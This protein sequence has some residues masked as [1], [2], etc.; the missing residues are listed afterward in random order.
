MQRILVLALCAGVALSACSNAEEAASEAPAAEIAQSSETVSSASPQPRAQTAPVNIP[1]LAYAYRYRIEAPAKS[2]DMLMGKHEAACLAAGP[3]VCQVTNA[4]L[5]KA[6]ERRVTGTLSLRARPEWMNAFRAGLSADAEA[7]DGK[8]AA[9]DTGTDD[10]SASI[11]DT[12]AAIR[13]KVI[14]R[15]RLEEFMARRSGKVADLLEVE[16]Q[17]AEVRGEID[18]AQSSLAMMRNRVRMSSITIDY[19]V[20]GSLAKDGAWRPVGDAVRNVQGVAANVVALM[21]LAAAV[22][23]PIALVAGS[24]ILLVRR[25]RKPKTISPATA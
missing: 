8:V 22:L 5:T 11:V 23:G 20:K 6:S 7:V 13:A 10:L 9:S 1:L 17:L 4:N 25:L 14:M 3:S 12:E 24:I 2:I 18:A 15:D 19:G 21:I 16:R